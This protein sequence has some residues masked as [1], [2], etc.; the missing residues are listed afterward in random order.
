MLANDVVSVSTNLV[1][2]E[3]AAVT[4]ATN[5][6]AVERDGCESQSTVR[7]FQAAVSES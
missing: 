7:P 6:V 5:G 3:K 4:V 1:G 2:L